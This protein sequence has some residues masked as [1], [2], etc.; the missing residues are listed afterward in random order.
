MLT[1]NQ[2]ELRRIPA[3]F[4]QTAEL[5]AMI[6]CAFAYM[7]GRIDPPSSIH[8]LTETALQHK[9]AAE[10]GI[11]ASVDGR[12]A[13]CVFIAERD[14]HFYLGKLAVD[15]EFQGRGIGGRLVAEAERIAGECG[16]PIIELQTRVELEANH[17]AFA[18][19]GFSEVGRTAHDGYLQ[20]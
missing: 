8:R 4:E 2:A 15:P 3:D 12:I 10:I 18:R 5:L 17:A 14:D 9:C 19:M 16:K 7:D 1:A 20:P 13:G 6:R 11:L